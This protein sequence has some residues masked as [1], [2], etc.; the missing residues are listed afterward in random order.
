MTTLSALFVSPSTWVL[1][2]VS[3]QLALAGYARSPRSWV[4]AMPPLVMIVCLLA[5]L[6]TAMGG[7][8]G[9]YQIG[10]GFGLLMAAAMV[11]AHAPAAMNEGLI[12]AITTTYW[13]SLLVAGERAWWGNFALLPAGLVAFFPTL[14]VAGAAATGHR[15]GR[16]MRLGLYLWALFAL[17]VVGAVRFPYSDFAALQ[18]SDRGWV[19][20]LAA[21]YLGAHIAMLVHNVMAL[22]LLLPVT[23]KG[24]TLNRRL[25][26]IEAYAAL[27]IDNYSPEPLGWR[28][29]ALIVAG[30]AAFVWLLSR[31]RPDGAGLAVHSCLSLC[32]VGSVFFSRRTGPEEPGRL[33]TGGD[34]KREERRR[35]ELGRK[36]RAD[37][38]S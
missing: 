25:K 10:M 29:A 8:P 16:A 26:E 28:K 38:A 36:A 30:Q 1:F 14:A 27:L 37:E 17:V 4:W 11:A 19:V 18:R 7:D 9:A 2:G 12:L 35:R 6:P 22:F 24:Q 34:L 31:W 5:A 3:G 32:L 15:P 21:S 33:P 23:S 13:I 20:I